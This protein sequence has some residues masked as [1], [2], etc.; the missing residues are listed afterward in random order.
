M[1]FKNTLNQPVK[2]KLKGQKTKK[3]TLISLKDNLSAIESKAILEIKP[4]TTRKIK[5]CAAIK[6]GKITQ[7]NLA[8]PFQ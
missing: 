1:K 5:Q 6:N 8:P 4:E 2:T 7:E 3:K